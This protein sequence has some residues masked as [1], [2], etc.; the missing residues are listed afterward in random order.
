M[1]ALQVT[2]QTYIYYERFPKD[3]LWIKVM[4]H[5]ISCI[6]H[7]LVVTDFLY[8]SLGFGTWSA[9]Y[10]HCQL[11]GSFSGRMLE[12]GISEHS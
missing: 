2:S 10:P 7:M 4:V 12:F 6:Y 9:H 5:R 11:I 3:R 1:N 8:R